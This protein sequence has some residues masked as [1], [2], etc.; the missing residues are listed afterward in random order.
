LARTL[1]VLD[2]ALDPGPYFFADRLT[3]CDFCLAL[4]AVW[5]EIYPGAIDDYPNLRRLVERVS[6]RLAVRKVLAEH[7]DER[8]EA[9]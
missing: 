3:V 1:R 2:E 7:G 6:R 9:N 5:P 4:Q 8:A